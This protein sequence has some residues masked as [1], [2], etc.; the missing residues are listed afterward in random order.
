[1]SNFHTNNCSCFCNPC[2]CGMQKIPGVIGNGVA[3]GLRGMQGPPGPPGPAGAPGP[4]GTPGVPGIPGAGAIIPFASGLPVALSTVLGGVAS[5]Q[6]LIGFGSS[7]T[8]LSVLG[9]PIDL[10]GAGGT[11][12]NLAFSVPRAGIIT[13]IS[14]FYS[15]FLAVN[16]LTSTVTIRAQ[17][18]RSA[19]PLSNVF[20]PIP[21]A[22]VTLAPTLTGAIALGFTSAG[23]TPAGLAIPVVQGERLLMVFSAEETG[24]IP[25]AASLEGYASAGV[26]IN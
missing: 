8:T 15:N 26:A 14:A 23:N 1:M 25:I 5:T 4:A 19:S 16:L 18:Y 17:L 21:G 13:S 3:R 22:I 6:G 9:G 24:G 2:V 11:L 12:L 20:N 10:T 7:G